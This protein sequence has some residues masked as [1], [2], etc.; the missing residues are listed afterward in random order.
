M[1]SGFSLDELKRVSLG[2]TAGFR[3][4]LK[5]VEVTLPTST[6]VLGVAGGAIGMNGGN[7]VVVVTAVEVIIVDAIGVRWSAP[8]AGMRSETY[9]W[10][11]RLLPV[12]GPGQEVRMPFIVRS[13]LADLVNRESPKAASRVA[14][15]SATVAFARG[16]SIAAGS[17]IG[18][19]LKQDGL[20]LVELATG[21][22][23]A[24]VVGAELLEFAV[25]GPGLVHETPGFV[26]GGFGVEAAA[27]G[28]AAAASLNRIFSNARI[29]SIV[30]VATATWT[31]SLVCTEL[32]PDELKARAPT[33]HPPPSPRTAGASSIATELSQLVQLHAQGALSDAEFA[34]AK[35]KLLRSDP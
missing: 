20:R 12:A 24:S 6:R 1:P 4:V 31:V 9:G 23:I 21:Q 33:V 18:L 30:R 16:L 17:R 11:V 8:L 14:G 26:G 25:D 3:R 10:G 27:T 19:D 5:Q 13:R 34:A 35:S 15:I 2:N 32:T 22:T 28:I 7:V 29:Q